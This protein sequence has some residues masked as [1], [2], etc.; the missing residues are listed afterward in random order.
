MVS[1][2][3]AVS[4]FSTV[5]KYLLGSDFKMAKQEFKKLS[6]SYN[7]K[8]TQ[9]FSIEF[10]TLANEIHK[11]ISDCK[12]I[13]CGEVDLNAFN[14]SYGA[15]KIGSKYF[16]E[17]FRSEIH[18]KY[19]ETFQ[20]SKNFN[21]SLIEAEKDRQEQQK[22]VAQKR[23]EQKIKNRTCREYIKYKWAFETEQEKIKQKQCIQEAKQKDT[24]IDNQAIKLGYKGFTELD[25]TSV[26]YHSQ[27]NG[28]LE[29]YLNYVIGCSELRFS[30]CDNLNASLKV[31]Q[32]LDNRIIYNYFNK[33]EGELL[34]YSVSVK[35]DKN[36]IY[37]EG[38]RFDNDFYV[39]DGMFTYKTILGVKRSI[40]NLQKVIVK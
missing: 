16:S 15:F 32:V 33:T 14:S 36:K 34:N 29:K 13:K 31:A 10:F 18:E 7:V 22:I 6:K 23:K 3:Y 2:T 37:Q 12:Q 38:Q 20:L 9:K 21:Q 19:K 30:D 11:K 5:E 26:I 28:N 40:P 27:K 1:G 39:F 4:D 17:P 8:L 24:F 25:I 35:K